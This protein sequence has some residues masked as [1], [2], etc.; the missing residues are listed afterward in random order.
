MHTPVWSSAKHVRLSHSKHSS[1]VPS[2]T[3][4]IPS[5]CSQIS[6]V[7]AHVMVRLYASKAF[8][9]PPY[10]YCS[11]NMMAPSRTWSSED[12]D[13]HHVESKGFIDEAIHA[14][15]IFALLFSAGLSSKLT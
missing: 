2:P 15:D 13:F 5:F 1:S 3:S 4:A 11:R 10:L 9:I 6:I 14:F 12:P 7:R 8:G